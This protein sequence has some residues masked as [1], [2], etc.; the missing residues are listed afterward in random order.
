MVLGH[1]RSLTVFYLVKFLS[2]RHVGQH[3]LPLQRCNKEGV[4]HCIRHTVYHSFLLFSFRSRPTYYMNNVIGLCCTFTSEIN[5]CFLAVA[6]TL[7]VAV[8]V[9]VAIGHTLNYVM[10]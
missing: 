5:K 8:A 6:V 7:A 2:V 1:I 3:I 4:K 9:A 10:V